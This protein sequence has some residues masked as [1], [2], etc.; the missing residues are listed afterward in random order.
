MTKKVRGRLYYFVA[1]TV[2][3]I[4]RTTSLQSIFSWAD[5][6]LFEMGLPA[7]IDVK[8]KLATHVKLA[9]EEDISRLAKEFKIFRKGE[10]EK[11]VKTG[12]L[13][14]VACVGDEIAHYRWVAFGPTNVPQIWGKLR[15][16]RDSVYSFNA[17]TVPKYR[18]LGLAPFVFKKVLDYL[19][20]KRVSKLYS[21]IDKRNKSAL[22]AG[23]KQGYRLIGEIIFRKILNFRTFKYNTQTA[24]DQQKLRTMVS[25]EI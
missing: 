23:Q 24:E 1:R 10:A 15:I 9:D 14:F 4:C 21:L 16:N 5:V 12:N 7:H 22:R 20:K 6:L 19:N 25:F 2:L 11:R 8:T 17:Y 13:C 3:W 18:G